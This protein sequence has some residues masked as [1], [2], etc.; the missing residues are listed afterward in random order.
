MPLHEPT[1]QQLPSIAW[2]GEPAPAPA[3]G[4]GPLEWFD[5]WLA[6]QPEAP[7]VVDGTAVHSYRELDQAAARIIR[8]L[9]GKVARGDLVGVC[10]ERS[11]L[12][13]AVAIALARIGAVYLSLGPQPGAARV[14]SITEDA[15]IRCLLIDGATTSPSGWT[16]EPADAVDGLMLALG[17]GHAKGAP[18]EAF[19]AVSTS[20]STGKP[21]IALL[22][23]GAM[24]NLV[25]WTCDRLEIG[26]E[27]RVGL[28]V[29][30][31][32]DAH[33]KEVWEALSSGATL[34]VAPEDAR[35]SMAELFQ[36]WQESG[37]THCLLPTPLAELAFAQPWPAGLAMRHILVGGDRMQVRPPAQ[38]TAV[39][40]NVYGPAEATVLT[41][42]H[43]LRPES[44]DPAA[45]VPIGEPLT[46]YTVLVTDE[47]GLIV[48]RGQAGEVRIGGAGL[49]L[50]YVDPERTAERFV[51]APAGQPYVD[52]VYR[53]GDKAVMRA[54]GLLEFLGRMDDQVKISGARIEPAEVEAALEA[55]ESVRHAVVVPFRSNTGTL[56]LGAFLLLA[57][58][59]QADEDAVLTAVRARVLKQA[60]PAVVRFVDAFP[61]NANGKVD[62]AVLAQQATP[63]AS[64][65]GAAPTPSTSQAED[66]EAFLL[67]ACRQLLDQ[68]DLTP[69]DNFTDA[70]GTSLAVARLVAL[71]ESV[72]PIRVKAAE[73]MRQPDLAALAALVATRR[74]SSTHR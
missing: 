60:V 13:V 57:E 63:A 59:A 50:G 23:Q 58:G 25:R 66:T 69:A 42:T 40:H 71:I 35:G 17:G 16:V 18:S 32:F 26:P 74:A 44:D 9:N 7:A 4:A 3:P 41:T 37:L 62:R 61:L 68:P 22:P 39:V 51:P 12:L 20:G 53:S 11:T 19:C 27:S 38:C 6:K 1:G 45:V 21:K 10:L 43:R 47:D 5:S 54:D 30:T 36:W 31:T 67:A 8:A 24:A 48:P 52:R 15:G 73:V 28:F 72:Y 70:G 14:K 29:G 46:G 34:Y 65:T 56:R 49:A 64:T 2:G 55:H 33:L